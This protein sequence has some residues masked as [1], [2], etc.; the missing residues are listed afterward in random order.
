MLIRMMDAVHHTSASRG[1]FKD[2]G[3]GT[4]E[5]FPCPISVT[6]KAYQQNAFDR[7]G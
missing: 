3:I 5:F 7:D 2:T 1:T 4:K 6:A